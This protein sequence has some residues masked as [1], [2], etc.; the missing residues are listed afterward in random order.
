[1]D[2]R[3]PSSKSRGDRS[4][5]GG[6]SSRDG[7]VAPKVEF[8]DHSIDPEYRDTYWTTRGEP[9]HRPPGIWHPALG[10]FY[11]GTFTPKRVV[12]LHRS[13]FQPDLPIKEE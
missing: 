9:K 13:R 10:D 5:P 2:E 6:S 7:N 12:A 1:M 3:K 4:V 11:W 8:S